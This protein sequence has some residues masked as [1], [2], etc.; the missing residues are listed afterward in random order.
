[1]EGVRKKYGLLFALSLVM[2]SSAWM[3]L[4][5]CCVP[6]YATG[7]LNAAMLIVALELTPDYDGWNRYLLDT[8]CVDDGPTGR[9]TKEVKLSC[10]RTQIEKDLAFIASYT[11]LFVMMVWMLFPSGWKRT[12]GWTLAGLIAL[13]DLLENLFIHYILRGF[14]TVEVDIDKISSHIASMF[15]ASLSKWTLLLILILW[16]FHAAVRWKGWWWNAIQLGLLGSIILFLI[17]SVWD[18]EQSIQVPLVVLFI[19]LV[20]LVVV[21]VIVLLKRQ[22]VNSNP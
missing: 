19:Y 20:L 15:D 9:N 13:F 4:E 2:L 6:S 10:L 1:M 3:R 11:L 5:K 8:S 16:M 21:F 7:S 12:A 14:K 17:M 22:T 18:L